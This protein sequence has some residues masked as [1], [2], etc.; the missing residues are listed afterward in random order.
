MLPFYIQLFVSATNNIN[1][2][3]SVVSELLAIAYAMST[4]LDFL[5]PV[6]ILHH[7]YTMPT[8]YRVVDSSRKATPPSIICFYIPS[9][10]PYFLFQ[11][12]LCICFPKSTYFGFYL[13]R[14]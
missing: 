10:F 5:R 8:L 7:R 3:R 1:C 6:L 9:V 14:G 2:F 12:L 11:D 13:F 4:F